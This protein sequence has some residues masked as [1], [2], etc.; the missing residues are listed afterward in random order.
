MMAAHA[1]ADTAGLKISE[2]FLPHHASKTQVAV[3]YPSSPTSEPTLYADSAIFEGVKAHLDG[4]V[5]PGHHPV[6]M[7]SH[8]MGGTD[9]AQAWFGAALAE[10]GAIVVIVNH[11]NSTWGNFDM[12]KGVKHWTRAA[13]LR[14]ALD[15]LEKGRQFAD[16]IDASR[17][18]AAGFSYGGWTALSMGGVR[19]NHAGIVKTCEAFGSSMEACEML[20]SQKGQ[21]AEH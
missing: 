16:K 3:W 11:P 13:D 8:G 21:H 12:S 4:P 5:T 19:G 15:A 17:I 18:M 6:I 10:R 20:L 14:V 7:F 9:R 1:Q 2:L